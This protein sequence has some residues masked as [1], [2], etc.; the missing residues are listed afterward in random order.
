MRYLLDTN[1]CIY[2]MKRQPP[3]VTARFATLAFGDVGMSSI[4]LAELRFGVEV[5]PRRRQDEAAL[6]D[7]LQD[8]MAMPFEHTAAQEYGRLRAL[9]R[10]RQR[11]ALDRLIAAHAA[12]LNCTLV[13]NNEPDFAGY[14]GLTVENWA[15]PA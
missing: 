7:L 8:V 5:S 14:P 1:I 6:D 10:S 3:E 2:L 15:R 4:T 13:T 9:V 11:D 12:S